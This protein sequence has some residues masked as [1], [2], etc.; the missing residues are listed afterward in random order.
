MPNDSSNNKSSRWVVIG[1]PVLSFVFTIIW[2]VYGIGQRTSKIV[3][4]VDWK[5]ETAPRIER[6]EAKGTNS[7]EIFHEEYLRTQTRQEAKTADLEKQIHDKEMA[8]L[9]ER[10][11]TLERRPCPCDK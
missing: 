1:I 11:L 5:A 2:V 7:F 4:V 8:E 10:I 9:K 6:M 3:E